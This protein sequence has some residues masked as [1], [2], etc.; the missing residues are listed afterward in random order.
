MEPPPSSS[1][2]ALRVFVTGA[3][4]GVGFRPFVHGLATDLG[5]AG[6]VSNTPQGVLT[7]VEGTREQLDAFLTRLAADAPPLALIED[8]R[9]EDIPVGERRGFVIRPSGRGERIQAFVTADAATCPDCLR[10]LLDPADRR[11]RY[12]FT[13]CTNCGPRFTI[14]RE[15]PYDR[16]TTTMAGFTMCPDCRREYEDPGDRRFHAQPNACPVCGPRLSFQPAAAGP[17]GATA[18]VWGEGTPSAVATVWGEE[19][20][21]QAT[22]L[23]RAGGILAV[24]GLGGYHLACD[25]LNERAVAGLRRRKA[26]DEKPFAVMAA[27]L[28]EIRRYCHVDRAEEA[29]LAG[30]RRPVVLLDRRG[31]AHLAPEVAPGVDTYGFFLPYTPLHH[32]LL[33]DAGRPL[34]MT[35]GNQSDEPIAYQDQDAAVRLG[36]LA[37]AFLG[38]D[39]P[40]HMRTDDSVARVFRGE[41]YLLRRARGWAPLPVVFGGS[42]HR[43]LAVG[44]Q[45]KNTFC[46]TRG[47]QA[48]LS[49]HIGDL[50]NLE[51]LRSLRE[52]VAH[53]RGLFDLEPDV[54]VHDLHPDYLST[55]FAREFAREHALPL[56]GVQHHEAH[57]AAVLADTRYD[58]AVVGLAFDG[59]GWGP[60]HTIWGGEVFAGTARALRREAH[61]GLLPLPGG[62]QAIRE[63][64]RLGLALLDLLRA[65]R[66]EADEA[67]AG[68]VRRLP[69]GPQL[70]ERP[71]QLVL[72]AA[73]RGVNTPLAS[74]AGRLF[75]AVSALLAFRHEVV[76]EGQ[77]AILLE[78]AARRALSARGRLPAPLEPPPWEVMPSSRGAE[79]PDPAPQVLPL[80]PYA[81]AVLADLAAG[82]PRD[83]IAARFHQSLAAAAADTA[84]RLAGRTGSEAVALSG[85]VFQNLLF[86]EMVAGRLEAAG[87]RVLVHRA[88]P[89]NDGGLCLGQA[90]IAAARLA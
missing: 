41:P 80:A 51:T 77:A 42:D 40:I 82:L 61:L 50:E 78:T 57:V 45:L 76:Y 56:L 28:D 70:L 36:P 20:L 16:A 87:L 9:W 85:G 67:L 81:A 63:P 5:L 32:L 69:E 68:W 22:A 54:V 72:Q 58:G 48:F 74:S 46:L 17:D 1:L 4:Q 39:R 86:L 62:E 31:S 13:N 21:A 47:R 90:E 55:R 11:Y 18:T 88:V 8:L 64:W 23:L 33:R 59:T 26:R 49:H 75:D 73:R 83:D 25:A 37:D 89:T 2:A 71:W 30:P 34:V 66:E 19:A 79:G 84:T 52:G 38:H 35:S 12:P 65:E 44:A 24:K 10:E 14:T 60:D 27:S 3:V 43:I 6:S 7:E 53:F 29:L 15:I